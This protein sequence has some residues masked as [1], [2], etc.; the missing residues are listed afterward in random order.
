[1]YVTCIAKDIGNNKKYQTCY[2]EKQKAARK[3]AG[4]FVDSVRDSEK[5]KGTAAQVEV[6]PEVVKDV[7]DNIGRHGSDKER[8]LNPEE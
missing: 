8:D 5:S 4:K 6:K 7:P 3:T 2:Y 1:M